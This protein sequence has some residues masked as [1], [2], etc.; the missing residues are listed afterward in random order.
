MSNKKIED[1]TETELRELY[2]KLRRKFDPKYRMRALI[3]QNMEMRAENEDIY[4]E[5]RRLNSIKNQNDDKLESNKR[6]I[7]EIYERDDNE[8]TEDTEDTKDLEYDV[9]PIKE[10]IQGVE[11]VEKKEKKA[12]KEISKKYEKAVDETIKKLY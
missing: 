7:E 4:E 8:D 2:E 12:K 10:E 9:E 11:V 6:E 5:I 3:K 1:L